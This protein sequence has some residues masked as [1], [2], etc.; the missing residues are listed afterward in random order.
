MNGAGNSPLKGSVFSIY[1]AG[2][3]VWRKF[4]VKSQVPITKTFK[5]GRY[6][7]GILD[8][9]RFFSP[10]TI[11]GPF[12]SR[13]SMRMIIFQLQTRIRDTNYSC[14]LVTGILSASRLRGHKSGNKYRLG[15]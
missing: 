3:L 13:K 14:T 2:E 8:G 1:F 12:H 10:T 11:Y 9:H 4:P 15:S 5:P 6:F 7:Y